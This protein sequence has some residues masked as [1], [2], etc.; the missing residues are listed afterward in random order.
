[1]E[2]LARGIEDPPK[3]RF[4]TVANAEVWLFETAA[5]L[6]NTY[7]WRC[8]GCGTGNSDQVAEEFSIA[9][10]NEH[11]GSCR[12]IPT[13]AVTTAAGHTVTLDRSD[14][15]EMKG[16]VEKVLRLTARGKTEGQGHVSP[17]WALEEI[18]HAATVLYEEL[19]YID[20][21]QERTP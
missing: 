9:S 20:R 17:R 14:L 10:A 4:A 1:M 15:A 16:T 3:L 5:V 13:R 11:A 19:D 12:A 2:Q 18:E 7:M 21:S 8:T 6:K